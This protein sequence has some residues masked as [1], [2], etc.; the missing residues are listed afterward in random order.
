MA[1]KEAFENYILTNY[2]CYYYN[3]KKTDYYIS[4]KGDV[5]SFKTHDHLKPAINTSGRYEVCMFIDGKSITEK[6]HRMVYSTYVGKIP[7]GHTINH[8][9]ENFHNNYYKNLEVMTHS[10]NTL[11]YLKNHPD[12]FDKK[13]SDKLVHELCSK[14]KSGIYYRVLSKEY[15]IPI[16]FMEGLVNLKVRKN[17]SYQYAPFPLSARRAKLNRSD[18]IKS[19]EKL[20]LDGKSNEEIRNILNL[21]NEN[22][23]LSVGKFIEDEIV[24]TGIHIIQEDF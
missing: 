10:E 4:D 22:V 11:E 3:D 6:V 12:A 15:D 2:R 18:D 1:L 8:I 5:Y 21:E 14:L 9:D 19:I 24:K 20:V 13:Y 7:D 23:N 16:S 17:I